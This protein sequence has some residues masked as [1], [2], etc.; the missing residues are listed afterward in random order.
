MYALTLYQPWGWGVVQGHKP[1]EN[2]TWGPP[3]WLYD[4]FFVIHA[5]Q[6]CERDAVNVV[7]EMSG[8]TYGPPSDARKAFIGVAKVLGAVPNPVIEAWP[9]FNIYERWWDKRQRGWVLTDGIAFRE[10]IPCPGQRGI[11]PVPEEHHE[12]IW[13][14]TTQNEWCPMHVR[15]GSPRHGR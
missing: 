15:F 8:C 6:R 1:L 5:G 10:P 12:A 11:W 3:E 13:R 7:E 4:R 2:R 14:Q 9:H